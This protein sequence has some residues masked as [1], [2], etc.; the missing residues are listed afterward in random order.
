MRGFTL[1]DGRALSSDGFALG[2]HPVDRRGERH[3]RQRQSLDTDLQHAHTI[4]GEQL[5]IYL[6]AQ[7]CFEIGDAYLAGICIDQVRQIKTAGGG[8]QRGADK[9]ANLPRGFIG[10]VLHRP[11]E[12]LHIVRIALH[13]PRHI[14]LNDDAQTV[15]CADILQT[16]GRGTQPQI[17]R[18]RCFERCRPAPAQSRLQQDP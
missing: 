3:R 14:G 2:T 4:S 9:G 8:F 15:P 1:A 16:A 11:H 18:D 10:L 13:L 6:L 7:L 12:T 5:L 17:H